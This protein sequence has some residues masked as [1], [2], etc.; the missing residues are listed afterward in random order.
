MTGAPTQRA[1]WS[2]GAALWGALALALA[3][4][5]PTALAQGPAQAVD[6]VIEDYKYQPAELTVKVGTTVRWVNREKRTSHSVIWLGAAGGV[7]SERFFP[8]ESYQR[9]FDKA[10]SYPYACGPHPEMKGIVIVIP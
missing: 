7:E 2:T 1:R 4:G 6:V 9:T 3:L 10:G 8:G 5:P